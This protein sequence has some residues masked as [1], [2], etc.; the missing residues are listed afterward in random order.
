MPDDQLLIDR[1]YGGV[2]VLWKK[3]ISHIVKPVNIDS[4]R[5][6]GIRLT[7]P[8]NKRVLLV[9][10]YMPCDNYKQNEVGPAFED[11]ID[12]LERVII[13]GIDIDSVIIAGDLNVDLNRKNAHS[14]YMLNFADRNQLKFAKLHRNAEYEHTY[15]ALTGQRETRSCIDHF[16]L[17][18]DL[19]NAVVRVTCVDSEE[20][21]G[22]NMFSSDS[23]LN[24]SQHIG[25]RGRGQGGGATA[26]PNSGK[27]VGEI[28]AKQE[29]KKLCVKCRAICVTFRANQPICPP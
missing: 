1:P 22:G 13:E 23:V 2:G 20:G 10:C 15:S 24:P 21:N 16:V 26:L 7:M 29:E 14:N 6:C 9:N 28:W 27:T 3:D 19:Y 17:S 12:A 8:D 5:M 25:V 4:K 11:A 18:G